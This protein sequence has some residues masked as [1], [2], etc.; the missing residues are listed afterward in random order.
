MGW[1]APSRHLSAKMV[2]GEDHQQQEPSMHE[3][4]TI[5]I[6]IAKHVFQIHGVD[7]A[8]GS[9]WAGARVGRARLPDPVRSGK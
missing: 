1:M 6:D 8:A 5:G 2:V 4:S 7:G 9:F 3:I